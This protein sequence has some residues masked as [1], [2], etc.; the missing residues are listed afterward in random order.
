[1]IYRFDERDAVAV[2]ECNENERE[3]AAVNRE[4]MYFRT[5]S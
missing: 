3:D 1:M 2:R 5:V 4:P